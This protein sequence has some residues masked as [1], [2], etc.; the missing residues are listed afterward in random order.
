MQTL[1]SD[2]PERTSAGGDVVNKQIRGSSL[3]LVGKLLSIGA[4]LGAQVLVVRHLSL[5]DYGAWAYALAAIGM[6]GAFAHLSLDKT[7]SRFTSIYHQQRQ[8]DLFFGTI[9]LVIGTVLVTGVLFVAGVYLLPGL[10]L[11]MTGGDQ[12]SL[13]LLLILIFLVPLEAIDTV[14]ISI[15]ATFGRARAIFLRRFVITPAVQLS[16]VLLLILLDADIV[17]LAFGYLAGALT[18][19]GI[20][21]WLLYQI[22]RDNGL[23]GD[24]RT[25]GIKVPARELFSFSFP[26][27]TSDWA[28]ALTQASGVLVMG[29]FYSTEQ[30]AFFRVVVPIAV[31][32]QLVIKSF[33]ALYVPSAARMFARSDLEGVN[34][35]YWR[36]SIWIAVLTFPLFAATFAAATPLT[37]LLFGE[38]YAESGLILAVLAIGQYVQASFGFNGATLKVLGK[39]R[40]LVAINLAAVVAN[41]ILA[42]LLVPPFGA[43]GAAVTMSVTMVLHNV[44]KQF[45]LRAAHI[46]AFDRSYMSPVRIIC[47]AAAVLLVVRLF[48]GSSSVILVAAAVLVSGVVVLSTKRVLRIHEVFPEVRRIPALRALLT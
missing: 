38:R 30:V 12:Q 35:L 29:Y 28:A 16:V 39:V 40:F 23:L 4:K 25:S 10:F 48:F 34:S 14:L 8:I 44:F 31:L 3:L 26:L 7:V 1:T 9:V 33:H 17:F 19:V 13:A 32:N 5:A 45:G 36:T 18:G 22:L 24:L 11:S 2:H 37:V 43:L 21:I 15:F 27:M 41:L 42:V 47:T 6:L 46:G 20:A